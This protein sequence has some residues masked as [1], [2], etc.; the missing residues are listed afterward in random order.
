M[1]LSFYIQNTK[2]WFSVA[3]V[4]NVRKAMQLSKIHLFQYSV[5]QY[6]E[7]F[8]EHWF[9]NQPISKMKP[10]LLGEEGKSTRGFKLRYNKKTSAYI[11]EVFTPS[12][13]EDW[14]LA[15]QFIKQLAEKLDS[16]IRNNEGEKFTS[17]SILN[18]DF[19]KDL[20]LGLYSIQN[21]AEEG[22]VIIYGLKRQIAFNKTMINNILSANSPV[23]AFSR[24]MH[25]IQYMNAHSPKQQFYKDEET[26]EMVGMY[27]FTQNINNI[28]PYTPSVDM[29]HLKTVTDDSVSKWEVC[30]VQLNGKALNPRAHKIIGTLKYADF[31]SHLPPDKYKWIDGSHILIESFNQQELNELAKYAELIPEEIDE[32]ETS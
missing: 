20:Y 22:C 12:T 14:L 23:D 24:T 6:A 1:S 32:T 2:K 28:L 13:R 3:P 8:D 9:F 26:K 29:E 5:D 16:P 27:S 25:E 17:S 30:L 10:L 7:D 11:V 18:F 31:I 19:E 4:L 21:A 15:L